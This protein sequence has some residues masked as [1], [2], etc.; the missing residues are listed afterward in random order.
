[1]QSVS[2]NPIDDTARALD[3]EWYEELRKLTPGER[4]KLRMELKADAKKAE[5]DQ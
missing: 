3:A 4:L 5:R 1:M 2:K